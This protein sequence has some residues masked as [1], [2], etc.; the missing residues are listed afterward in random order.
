MTCSMCPTPSPPVQAAPFR[1][2]SSHSAHPLNQ[3]LCL[4]LSHPVSPANN[5]STILGKSV[6]VDE[7][8]AYNKLYVRGIP[9][10]VDEATVKEELG[11]VRMLYI[12]MRIKGTKSEKM[13]IKDEESCMCRG[14]RGDGQGGARQGEGIFLFSSLIIFGLMCYTVS[15]AAAA[16]ASAFFFLFNLLTWCRLN[17]AI[18]NI[19]YSSDTSASRT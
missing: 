5:N 16:A 15:T 2:L 1:N 7:S 13:C 3:P 6:R 14:R 10:E 9:A 12:V 19:I 11:K 18:F 17:N 4:F 8:T